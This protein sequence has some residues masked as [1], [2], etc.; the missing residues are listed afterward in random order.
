VLY[1]VVED[2]RESLVRWIKVL[3]KKKKKPMMRFGYGK[4]ASKT[5]T[6]SPNLM[7]LQRTL[8]SDTE[9]LFSMFV[10]YVGC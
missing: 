8:S 5:D 2:R 10:A 9:W 3:M 7:W 6:M 4:M 1:R